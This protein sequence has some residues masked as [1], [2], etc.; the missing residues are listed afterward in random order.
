MRRPSVAPV[1]RFSRAAVAR[2]GSL[3]VVL[4]VLSGIAQARARY[5]YC[6][7]LGLS[8]TDPCAQAS[9]RGPRCPDTSLDGN[10]AD[11][12]RI[13]TMSPL[14]EGFRSIEPS[15]PSAGVAAILPPFRWDAGSS[16]WSGIGYV[17]W[18]GER[19]RA[20]PRA[21]SERRAQLM[22]FHT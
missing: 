21:P 5:F 20:P 3:L 16:S 7:A 1:R 12:C 2:V 19:W 9:A 22:V 4:A 18:E 8:T 11:C 6:E 13:I 15:V 14:P 10:P 17:A